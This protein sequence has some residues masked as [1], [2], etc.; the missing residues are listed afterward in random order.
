MSLSDK[1]CG[2][3]KGLCVEE[4]GGSLGLASEA[5]QGASLPLQSVHHIHGGHR[6]PLGV[7]RVCDGVTDH[8]LQENL[9]HT[10]GLLVDQ[11]RD[12]LHS[13]TTSQTADGGL[14]DSLD[15]ITENFTVT[16]SASF[17]ESFAS[18]ASSA[19]GWWSSCCDAIVWRAAVLGNLYVAWG[20]PRKQRRAA[21]LSSSSAGCSVGEAH[22]WHLQADALKRFVHFMAFWGSFGCLVSSVRYN[23]CKMFCNE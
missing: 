23:Q 4:S 10:A 21:L 3:E 6:L 1:V 5:V 11:T 16:L 12:S 22:Y 7:L 15:V 9:Q 2:P 14:G 8:V 18:F 20:R 19:H 13:A 17:P